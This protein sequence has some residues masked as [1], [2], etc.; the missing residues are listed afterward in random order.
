MIGAFVIF[1]AMT[2][3]HLFHLLDGGKSFHV[4]ESGTFAALSV[5]SLAILYIIKKKNCR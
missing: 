4:M 5:I 3:V 1:F 2:F